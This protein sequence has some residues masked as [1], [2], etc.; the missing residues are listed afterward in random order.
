MEKQVLDRYNS[1]QGAVSYTGKFDRRF[2]E[3]VNNVVEQRLVRGMLGMLPKMA[4]SIDV[5]C[6]YGRMYP[7]IKEVSAQVVE[8][9]WSFHLLKECRARQLATPDPARGW[10][11]ATALRLPYAD[12]C[13][14]LIFSAR[15]CHHINAPEER[16]QYLRELLRVSRRYVLFTYFDAASFKNRRRELKRLFVNTKSKYTMSRDQVARIAAESGYKILQARALA[17]LFSG[18]RYTLLER[19]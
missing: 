13:V 3:R 9:D 6:G 8:C 16:E 11:R 1:P 7:L 18:H 17:P 2:A 12:A 4:L 14:D 5:P 10:V 15:L 19:Q